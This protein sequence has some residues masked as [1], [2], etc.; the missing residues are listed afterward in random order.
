MAHRFLECLAVDGN[1]SKARIGALLL[2]I[3]SIA[4]FIWLIVLTVN[5]SQIDCKENPNSDSTGWSIISETQPTCRS[6]HIEG[7]KEVKDKAECDKIAKANKD[8]NFMWFAETNNTQKW[9][10]A[11]YKTCYKSK[12]KFSSWAAGTTYMKDAN[13][14]F[15][16][17][18]G[19]MDRQRC[20]EDEEGNT[21]WKWDDVFYQECKE[22]AIKLTDAKF[23][24][25]AE[26][27]TLKTENENSEK[28][29]SRCEL[30]KECHLQN[31]TTVEDTKK[32]VQP[33]TIYKRNE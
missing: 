28:H 5:M 18:V 12:S 1:Y 16:V 2:A 6:D 32:F 31:L 14:E 19:K 33:F 8:A 25:Y 4:F 27:F 24:M 3:F 26:A 13:G 23:M 20:K 17:I 10:C 15:D 29:N 30:Y 21:V 11:L 22:R 7:D 9:Y